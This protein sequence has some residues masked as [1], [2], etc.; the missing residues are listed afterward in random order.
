M[1]N[2]DFRLV[3]QKII[4]NLVRHQIQSFF[5]EVKNNQ[6]LLRELGKT[7]LSPETVSAVAKSRNFIFTSE[8]L[9]E[10]IEECIS[11]KLTP[12]EVFQRESFMMDFSPLPIDIEERDT[13]GVV[14]EETLSENFKLDRA[15]LLSGNVVV[16]RS[17]PSLMS[18]IQ[19][20]RKTLQLAL[21][22][23]DLA[24]AHMLVSHS[25][26]KEKAVEANIAFSNNSAVPTIIQKIVL[27][28][29]MNIDDVLWEWPGF[30]MFFPEGYE[31]QGAYRNGT[32]GLLSPHR[33]TWYGSPQHQIN[34]WGPI[35]P[36]SDDKTLRILS[37]FHQKRVQNSSG[38]RDCWAHNLGL[39]LPPSL[40]EDIDAKNYLAPP[41]NVGDVMLFSGHSLHSSAPSEKNRTRVTFEFRI[42]NKNDRGAV[43]TPLNIDYY[44]KGEIYRNW[45]DKEGIQ[46]NLYSG[47]PF[48]KVNSA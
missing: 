45:H 43:Y 5:D 18:L 11:T 40:L 33:D 19:L 24:N 1:Q 39:A 41:L 32:T 3:S 26:L 29:G 2:K 13:C 6:E 12:E 25:I 10:Y 42:L 15:C 31:S 46:I 38:G 22:I 47:K 35:E 8:Q 4:R 16:I 23:E 37:E 48:E 27:E 17:S 14:H 34:F 28:L 30:R 7:N 36:I 20:M 44:G 9:L 21:G